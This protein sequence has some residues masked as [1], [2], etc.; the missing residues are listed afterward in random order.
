MNFPHLKYF[1]GTKCPNSCS[2]TMMEN[3]SMNCPAFTPTSN[4]LIANSVILPESA[5]VRTFVC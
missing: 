1:A 4:Q 3:E 2:T 5:S